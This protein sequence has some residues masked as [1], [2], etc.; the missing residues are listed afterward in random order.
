MFDSNIW[1]KLERDHQAFLKL[2]S[3][4]LAGIIQILTTSIQ[5]KENQSAPSADTFQHLKERLGTKNVASEG[6]VLGFAHL[7]ENKFGPEGSNWVTE[8]GSRNRDEVIG[9]TAEI[10]GAWLI[11]EDAKFRKDASAKG[12]QSYTL[13]ELLKALELLDS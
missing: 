13:R 3:R 10:N 1:D 4:V 9:Q 11:T 6:V 12:L 7:G 2:E 8:G 5:E